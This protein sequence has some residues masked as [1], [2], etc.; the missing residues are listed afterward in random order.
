MCAICGCGEATLEG[1]HAHSHAELDDAAH[2]ALH[3]AGMPHGH[4]HDAS[5]AHHHGHD[6]VHYGAGA[7]GVSVPGLDQRQIIKLERAVLS[8]NDDRAEINRARFAQAGILTLNLLS[9][10]GSGKTTLL[11]ET[12]KAVSGRM[13]VAVIEGDQQ[14]SFDAD[15]IRETGAPAI[16]V[17]TGKGCHLDAAMVAD[18]FERLAPGEGTVLF[19]E[20]VGNLVCPAAFDLGE[21]AKV[22][23]LSITEGEDKPLKY[24][25]MFAAAD[26]MILNKIDL[27][28]YVSFNVERCLELTHRVNP[29]LPVLQ[30]SATTGE[31]LDGWVLWIEAQLAVLAARRGA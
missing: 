13:A 17:N 1:Q 22:V 14:T 5:H 10:P 9:S 27:A 31:G 12:I 25:D 30:L 8:H 2:A 19:V 18:A 28:P 11:C 23:I 7:A 29:G 6:H 26:L 20:N 4:G 3:A 16:Q 15:R 24:P 21:A